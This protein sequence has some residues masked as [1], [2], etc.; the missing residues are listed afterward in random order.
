[1]GTQKNLRQVDNSNSDI[2]G[3]AMDVIVPKRKGVRLW[4]SIGVAMAVSVIAWPIWK[5][6]PHGLAVKRADMNIVAV[7]RGMFLDDVVA[8][9]TAMPL[10]SVVLDAIAGGRVDEVVV[11]DGADIRKGTLLFRLS[12]PQLTLDLLARQSDQAQQISN[13]SNLRVGL[14]LGRSEAQHRIT[15]QEHE[16]R[17][18]E[19]N[20]NT[21]LRLAEH[22]FISA[23]ALEDTREQL[24]LARDL[25]DEYKRNAGIEAKIRSDAMRQMEQSMKNIDAGLGLVTAAVDALNVRAP[26]S[27]RLA[28]FNLL[29][30]TLVK[31]GDHI[32]RIDEP[33]TFKLEVPVD[34]FYLNRVSI[35]L[36]AYAQ[37]NGQKHELAV[38]RIYPQIKAGRFTLDLNFVGKPPEGIHPG[39]TVDA[40][41]VLGQPSSALL[42]PNAAFVND[43]GGA[44]VYVMDS[45][46]NTASK[47]SIRIGRRN[48]QQLEV[49]SGLA[50]GEQ[51]VVSAYALYSKADRLD[52]S[53]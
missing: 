15:Q 38:N 17:Q 11:K 25:L 34:E 4:R 48:N 53:Q 10:N 40:H 3:A 20:Y 26:I 31:P 28:D 9:A 23:K 39:Q 2:S 7:S 27:G 21:N 16:L 1:M 35:G 42:L 52:I 41:L 50:E 8:R 32:G 18:A 44:W 49:V 14:E 13:L 51:V 33:G 5:L 46:G 24:K 45:S 22:G 19:R 36:P 12:N 47:R 29:V 6:V 43:T 37:I 30:G